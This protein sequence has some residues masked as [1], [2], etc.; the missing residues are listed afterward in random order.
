MK[1]RHHKGLTML[2]TMM[3]MVVAFVGFT[4]LMGTLVSTARYT[5]SSKESSVGTMLAQ[6]ELD[7]LSLY[8]PDDLSSST[9]SFNPPYTD[10]KYSIS[11][12]NYASHLDEVSVVVT[13]PSGRNITLENL[14]KDLQLYGLAVTENSTGTVNVVYQDKPSKTIHHLT[15]TLGGTLTS[16]AEALASVT[17]SQVSALG[18]DP[19]DN[20]VWAF[21]AGSHAAVDVTL[22]NGTSPSDGNSS[23][24]PCPGVAWAPKSDGNAGGEPPTGRIGGIALSW[25]TARSNCEL[26]TVVDRTNR[27]IDH[28]WLFGHKA[29]DWKG[30]DFPAPPHPLGEP[31]GVAEGYGGNTLWV[32]DITNLCLRHGLMNDTSAWGE[33]WDPVQYRPQGMTMPLGLACTPWSD[34]VFVDDPC[35]LWIMQPPATALS[36]STVTHNASNGTWWKIPL[37]AALQTAWPSGLSWDNIAGDYR[38]PNKTV[39]ATNTSGNLWMLDEAGGVWVVS[40][41]VT[42]LGSNHGPACSPCGC[43]DCGMPAGGSVN[44]S[45]TTPPVFTQV[46]SPSGSLASPSGVVATPMP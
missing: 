25:D 12:Q 3:A 30:H 46:Y 14:V 5:Q 42:G 32:G 23:G 18:G 8:A 40:G 1:Q 15:G 16:T 44:V 29:Y 9:G 31:L 41:L 21:D 24:V 26:L 10:Y 28:C 27:W 39:N 11:V 20:M 4:L 22:F 34:F 37:P 6:S 35:N 7:Q 2:E 19:L 38:H 13:T 17:P 43:G 36:N 45:T 33:S